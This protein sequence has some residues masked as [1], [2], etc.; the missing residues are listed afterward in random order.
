MKVSGKGMT[1]HTKNIQNIYGLKGQIKQSP[2]GNG[3]LCTSRATS[4]FSTD[5]TRVV[6][7]SDGFP[8]QVIKDVRE[9]DANIYYCNKYRNNQEHRR[10]KLIV[11]V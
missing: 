4:M 3:T 6:G 7:V 9:S 11:S 2:T 10:V 5:E 8:T 1:G